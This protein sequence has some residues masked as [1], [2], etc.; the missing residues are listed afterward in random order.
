[1]IASQFRLLRDFFRSQDFRH[2]LLI[3]GGAFAALIVLAFAAGLIFPAVPAQ[4]LTLFSQQMADAGVVSESGSISV[5]AL[6]WNNLRAMVLSVLYG[7]IPFIYLP[8]LSLGV[9]ALLLGLFAAYF[10]NNGISIL[11]YLGGILPQCVHD[12]FGLVHYQ[13]A[14]TGPEYARRARKEAEQ[15]GAELKTGTMVTGL[16]KERVVTAVTRQGLLTCRAGAV[17][18]ATG[19]R[20]RTRGAIAIPGTRP[21]MRFF[22]FR[23]FC[24]A[25]S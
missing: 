6:L 8:A 20:E 9:N 16:T 11:A 4:V 7:F 10:L 17:V 23:R 21:T 25:A 13:E 14:L 1:M 3:T 22:V 15:A 18:L 12:G 2:S 5:P 19:C 24:A